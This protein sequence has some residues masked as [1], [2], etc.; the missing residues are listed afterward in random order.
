VEIPTNFK[1]VEEQHR[2]A[3]QNYNEFMERH[4]KCEAELKALI[5]KKHSLIQRAIDK[6]DDDENSKAIMAMN[7]TSMLNKLRRDLREC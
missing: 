2:V 1:T 7:P 5:E 3:Y 4:Y 6:R